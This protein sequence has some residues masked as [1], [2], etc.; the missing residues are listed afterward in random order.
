MLTS[1]T[2]LVYIMLALIRLNPDRSNRLSL[3]KPMDMILGCWIDHDLRLL[4]HICAHE[5][6]RVVPL[7][8]V[9][10]LIGHHWIVIVLC[11]CCSSC[12]LVAQRMVKVGDRG[13][14]CALNV[15]ELWQ[16]PIR[17]L[18]VIFVPPIGSWQHSLTAARVCANKHLD[19]LRRGPI[20]IL[21]WPFS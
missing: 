21:A 7:M 3:I 2:E 13:S 15:D 4:G 11:C 5:V 20:D 9:G 12:C 10:A 16:F 14:S 19:L 6:F 17:V 8:F 18:L 1:M